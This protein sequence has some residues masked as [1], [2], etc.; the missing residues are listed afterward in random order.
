VL[1][2]S[3]SLSGHHGRR[4]E[5]DIPWRGHKLDAGIASASTV[6]SRAASKSELDLKRDMKFVP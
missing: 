5:I 6:R 3:R 2:G 1:S 4:E